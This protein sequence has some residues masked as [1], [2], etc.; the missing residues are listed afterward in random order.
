[1]TST[2]ETK[3]TRK[4]SYVAYQVRDTGSGKSFFN[5]IGVAFAHKDSRGYDILLEA[6]PLDGRIC[7]RDIAEKKEQQ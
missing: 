4:P 5:R 2:T 3:T 7:L 6:V 1:M